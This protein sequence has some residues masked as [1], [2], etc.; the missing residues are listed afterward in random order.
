MNASA[1]RIENTDF[2]NAMEGE[3]AANPAA[4][5]STITTDLAQESAP[6][7][8]LQVAPEMAQLL[9]FTQKNGVTVTPK[10]INVH[11]AL[12][13]QGY[14]ALS[15]AY[16][17]NNQRIDAELDL[18][19]HAGGDVSTQLHQLSADMYQQKDALASW[20]ASTVTAIQSVRDG[21]QAQIDGSQEQFSASVAHLQ[22]KVG[23]DLVQ[24][25]TRL[26]EV[27]Q[28]LVAQEGII[29]H[30]TSR[31]D[32]FDAAYELLNSATR[33]NKSRIEHVREEA[34]T[35]QALLVAQI[36]GQSALM[37]EHYAELQSVQAMTGMLQTETR[38]LDG[39]I[40]AVATGLDLHV[41]AT[42][43]RFKWTHVAMASM[44]VLTVAG[45]A[46][47]KWAPAFAP[48]STEL[49]LAQTKVDMAL[50][51]EQLKGQSSELLVLQAA[52]K[53]QKSQVRKVANQV[54]RLEETLNAVR[55]SV[56]SLG[57]QK[58]VAV[59]AA[60][61]GVPLQGKDWILQQSP[62]A[63]T[64]QM[65]GVFDQGEMN[66][67]VEQHGPQLQGAGLAYSVTQRDQRDRFNVF[68]GV[69][70][71]ANQA[72]DAISALPPEL[73]ANKPWVRPMRSVQ[74]TLQ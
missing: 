50:I 40:Q 18:I 14:D 31:L 63:F 49:A 35:Q 39:A 61:M 5:I 13:Q 68:Y 56:K 32:Q 46:A 26:S 59:S 21:L 11:L 45:F 47:V 19:R 38:R 70:D 66:R 22:S 58:S 60:A 12:V 4:P 10:E 17:Q 27:K 48:V 52:D 43:H 72:Q 3:Q 65:L 8:A 25:D 34:Q 28:L 1:Q 33:G 9:E 71:T 2:P 36:D 62:N 24:I 51:N 29:G 67:F 20:S 16:A 64:V 23:Q 44:L 55:A 42:H 53:D 57:I 74:D 37:R 54:D 7:L 69:F 73:R 15:A 6:N 41:A 30:Q